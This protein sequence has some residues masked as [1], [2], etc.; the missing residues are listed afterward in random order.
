M[1]PEEEKF[2]RNIKGIAKGLD[3][4]EFGIVEYSVVSESGRIFA[5]QAQA[6]YV[7]GLRK[8]L[9]IIYPQLIH[10]SEGY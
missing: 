7:P 1:N 4:S 9:R 3:I 6:Y 8:D 5:L 2:A 10:T